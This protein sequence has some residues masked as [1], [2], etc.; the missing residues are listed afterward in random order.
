MKII[1]KFKDYYDSVAWTYGGGDPKI[2]YERLEIKNTGPF[3]MRLP[4]TPLRHK[5]QYDYELR[6]KYF[7]QD[8]I[9]GRRLY[10]VFSENAKTSFRGK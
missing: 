10:T 3:T 5:W 6:N 4:F 8:L 2:R 7:E 9:V 1:S